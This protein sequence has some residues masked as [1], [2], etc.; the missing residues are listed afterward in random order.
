MVTLLEIISYVCM[1]AGAFFVITGAVGIV[2][3]PD[4][5]TRLHPAGIVDSIG[6]PL[7][8]MGLLFHMGLGIISIKILLLIA[9]SMVTSST[10]CHALAKAALTPEKKKAEK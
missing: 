6:V 7:I 8:L 9:F 2:R 4:F 10:A 1:A 3:M 5:F